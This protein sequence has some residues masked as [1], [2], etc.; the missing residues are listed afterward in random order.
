VARVILVR[1]GRAAAAW[2]RDPDPGLD[3]V[4]RAQA[5]AMADSVA[6]S[7]RGPLPVVVSPLR[8]TRETARALE[9]RWG[10]EAHIDAAVGE[11]P[12]PTDD[13]TARGAWLREIMVRN[14]ADVDPWLRTW[15][16]A[17]LTGLRSIAT[18]DAVVVTHFVAINVIVGA[19]IDDD[20]VVCS[21]PDYCSQTTIELAGDGTLHLVELGAQGQTNVR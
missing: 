15:R 7:C 18:A 20:R 4:G 9:T 13:L 16:S 1:H 14:W 3:D 5:D 19:A 21:Y 12:S 11:I 17:V 6:S 2:D 10:V 8:R